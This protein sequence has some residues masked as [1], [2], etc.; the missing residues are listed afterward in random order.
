M[1]PGERHLLFVVSL[2]DSGGSPSAII[3]P[4]GPVD[5][6]YD[7]L[8]RVLREAVEEDAIPRSDSRLSGTI[9]FELAGRGDRR[10]HVDVREGEIV[11]VPLD[12]PGEPG[13]D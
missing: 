1:S 11:I 10:F 2:L 8:V 3:R 9:E 6:V 4:A 13:R 7:D 5:A 12:L